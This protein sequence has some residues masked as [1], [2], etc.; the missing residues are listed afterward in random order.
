MADSSNGSSGLTSTG[1]A[2]G[3]A[4]VGMNSGIDTAGTIKKI[5]KYDRKPLDRTN[6]QIQTL[7]WKEEAYRVQNTALSSMR[8]MVFNLKMETAYNIRNVSSSDTQVADATVAP[9]AVN[10]SYAIKVNKLATYSSNSSTDGP[11]ATKKGVFLSSVVTASTKSS[12]TIDRTHHSLNLTVDGAEVAVDLSKLSGT[13]TAGNRGG[14]SLEHLA[15]AMEGRIKKAFHKAGYDD[16]GVKVKVTS[17]NQLEFYTDDGLTHNIS[18][19]NAGSNTVLSELGFK[20]GASISSI[21]TSQS[22]YNLRD[23]FTNAKSYFTD[24]SSPTDMINFAINGQ[25][26]QFTNN[27]SLDTIIK[28]IN[29]TEAAGVNVYFDQNSD[30]LM[31]TATQSGDYNHGRPGIVISDTDGVLNKL[32]KMDQANSMVGENADFVVNGAPFN[33]ASNS[34]AMNGVTLKLTGTG[35]ATVSV[36]SDTKEVVKMID[37]FVKAYNKTLIGMNEQIAQNRPTKGGQ[38]YEPL[39]DD[40]KAE[41]SEEQIK[42]WEGLAQQGL[43]N[44]DSI[45]MS[46]VTTLRGQ[47][48]RVVYTPITLAGGHLTEATSFT[49]TANQ[50][51]FTLGDQTKQ[52]TLDPKIYSGNDLKSI[53]QGKVNDAFGINR[54]QVGLSDNKISFTSQNINMTVSSGT[55]NDALSKLGFIS[56]DSVKPSFNNLS[57]IGIATGDYSENGRLHLDTNKLNNALETDPEG[58]MRLLTNTRGVDALSSNASDKFKANQ[59]TA[60]S[61][62]VFTSFYETLGTQVRKFTDQAGLPGGGDSNSKIGKEIIKDNNYINTLQ[63]RFDATEQRL[64]KTFNNMEKSM[65][66]LGNQ[67]SMLQSMGMG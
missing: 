56:G 2:N 54:I 21:D 7:Q 25:T 62:G 57:Q 32:F 3:L 8:D 51:T 48:S 41:M 52:I 19:R 22:L 15:G 60:D 64:W 55:Q 20:D 58:V 66:Q 33:Q 38:H 39:T 5:M 24:K 34:I 37:D 50:I 28:R 26:F 13:Y 9:N 46:T 17:A 53:L 27:D 67:A 49:P 16:M 42:K 43:L 40:Q 61:K 31:F 65:G 11:K 10:G 44:N 1:G 35:S 18:L 4:L 12:I 36:A 59:L 29:S 23:Q 47:M 30:K 63:K 6:Q 14:R 45:L